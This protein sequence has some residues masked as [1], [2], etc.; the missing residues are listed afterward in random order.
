MTR[1]YLGLVVL[2]VGYLASGYALLYGLG[3]VRSRH[4]SLRHVGLALFAGWALV[5][6]VLTIAVVL[7]VD[8]D[9][10]STLVVV[11]VTAAG[12]VALSRFL[13]RLELAAMPREQERFRRLAALCGIALLSVGL[14]SALGWP[15]AAERT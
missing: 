1:A 12:G 7:G 14:A 4:H 10:S 3:I 13:P 8:P 6:T 2:D 11:L 5:A 9:V 15:H